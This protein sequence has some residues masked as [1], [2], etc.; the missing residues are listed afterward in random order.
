[1]FGLINIH[2]PPGVTSR[3]VVNQVQ[4]LVRPVKVGHAGTLDP[5]ATG[6]LILCLGRATRLIPY[7]QQMH[8]RYRGTFLL[9]RTSDTEDVEGE[10][11]EIAGVAVP[12]LEQIDAALPEFVG[13]MQ[14]R[15]PAFS[16]LKVKGQRAYQLARRGELPELS[17]RPVTVHA[18]ELVRYDYPTLE[19]DIECGSGTYVRSLGRDLAERLGTAAV[20]SALIRTAIGG[21][22]LASAVALDAIS[23]DSIRQHLLDPRLA[24]TALPTVTLDSSELDLVRRGQFIHDRFGSSASKDAVE[25]A[26]VDQAGRL[27]AILI[28]R[29][30]DK[31]GAA[32]NFSTSAPRKGAR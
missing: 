17:P 25:L 3:D 18:L 2:K 5:L 20:M 28:R 21:F 12:T 14:Q 8:K 26:A 6:V 29:T 30:G 27:V 23:A 15:P 4:Q 19:L 11:V 24:L 32:R 13:E 9:G 22:D 1:M 16:A 31:W 10:V 7:V